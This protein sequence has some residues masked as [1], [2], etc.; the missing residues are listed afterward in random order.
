MINRVP[1]TEEALSGADVLVIAG[2]SDAL[3]PEEVE[4]LTRFVQDGGRLCVM[5]GIA[6]PARPLVEALGVSTSTGVIQERENLIGGMPLNFRVTSLE[7]HPITEGLAGFDVFGAW[8]LRAGGG[9]AKVIARTSPSAWVDLNGNAR[10]DAGDAVQSFGVVVAGT[11]GEGRFV[12]FGDDAM[13][14]NRHL[15]ES[16]RQLVKNLAQWFL[17]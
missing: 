17:D 2:P 3:A 4:T 15:T 6:W 13:F 14:Q 9:E 16:N 8:A 1:I 7:A 10:L 12:V 5:L 11:L